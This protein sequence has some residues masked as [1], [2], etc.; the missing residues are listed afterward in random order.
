MTNKYQINK[1]IFSQTITSIKHINRYIFEFQYD[2]IKS[3][4]LH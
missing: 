2:S 3:D 4:V 1:M